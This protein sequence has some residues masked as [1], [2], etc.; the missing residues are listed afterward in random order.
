MQGTWGT[1]LC[2][3]SRLRTNRELTGIQ[4]NHRHGDA[5]ILALGRK[6]GQ[7]TTNGPSTATISFN[8]SAAFSEVACHRPAIRKG[9]MRN[10]IHS[11]LG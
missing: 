11:S 1:G 5:G 3:V 7:A 4:V 10:G 2:V 6:T 8:C 9:P